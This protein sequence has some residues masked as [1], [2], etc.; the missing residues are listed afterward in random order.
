MNLFLKLIGGILITSHGGF[1]FVLTGISQQQ[2]SWQNKRI[3]QFHALHE[4]VGLQNPEYDEKVVK[5]NEDVKLIHP[6]KAAITK[7]GVLSFVASMCIALPAT[8]SPILALYRLNIISKRTKEQC[9]LCVGQFCSR[10]LMKILPFANIRVVRDKEEQDPVPTIWACNHTSMLDI[11][12]LLAVDKRLR[13]RNKRPI[14]I[15]YW[16]DLEKNPVTKLLFVMCG[17][18]SVEMEDN[19][20]GNNNAYK[21]SSFRSLLKDT[22]QAFDE[23]FDIGILPE[24]QLNLTPENGL[25]PIFPGAYT[26]AKMSRRPIRMLGIHGLNQ[27]WHADE[28]IGITV[29]GRKVSIRAYPAGRKFESADQFVTAFENIVGHYGA[30]GED[31]PNWKEWLDGAACEK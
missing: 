8:L 12:L 16:K 21:T 23:G 20:N 27:L 22:K 4:S 7:V 5:S 17:F 28:S 25:S 26:L 24:G 2:S 19:G 6:L 15:I 3:A 29:T 13:G 31:L 11:F 10:W 9:S 30:T 18:I 14:K 1:G